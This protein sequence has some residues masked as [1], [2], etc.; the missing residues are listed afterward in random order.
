[1]AKK[2]G[3]AKMPMKGAMPMKKSD[4]PMKGK[5]PMMPM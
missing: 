2:S 3:G 1:M 5:M 4:M